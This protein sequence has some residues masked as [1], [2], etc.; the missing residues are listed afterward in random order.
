MISSECLA[1]G[2]FK[3]N[4]ESLYVLLYILTLELNRQVSSL[5]VVQISLSIFDNPAGHRMGMNYYVYMLII[6]IALFLQKRTPQ[7]WPNS[8]FASIP[9]LQRL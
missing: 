2:V 5:P 3:K 7:N 1:K 9:S 4:F 8:S 6:Y